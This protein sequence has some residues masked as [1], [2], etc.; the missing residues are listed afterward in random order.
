MA[1]RCSLMKNVIA[2]DY[3]VDLRRRHSDTVPNRVEKRRVSV[4][5][6]GRRE[7][8]KSL[9]GLDLSHICAEFPLADVAGFAVLIAA[10]RAGRSRGL[11][12]QGSTSPPKLTSDHHPL[13][14]QCL[15][16]SFYCSASS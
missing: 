6:G 14:G 4:R 7:G 13:T 8:R 11:L 15:D 1:S 2:D 12:L 3:P 5:R 16:R 10:P 9:E